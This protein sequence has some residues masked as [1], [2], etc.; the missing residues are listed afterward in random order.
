MH[1]NHPQL[2]HP[3]SELK[4]SRRAIVVGYII[5][6]RILGGY[7]SRSEIRRDEEKY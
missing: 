1:N 5:G 3:I 7:E 6:W 4:Q 2:D